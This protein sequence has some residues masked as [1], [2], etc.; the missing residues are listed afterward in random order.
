MEMLLP[1]HQ[2]YRVRTIVIPT[3]EK[4]TEVRECLSKVNGR[5]AK[6]QV[7]TGSLAGVHA[8]IHYAII[9][10]Q[11]NMETRLLWNIGRSIGTDIKSKPSIRQSAQE[12]CH[13]G[14]KCLLDS[15][16]RH[17]IASNNVTGQ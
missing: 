3:L 10:I 12:K 9:T 13:M 2:F 14:I 11:E 4:A 16:V 5:C 7:S 15:Q 1:S 17:G 8:C 6:W